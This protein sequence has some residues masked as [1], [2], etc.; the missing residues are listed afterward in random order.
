MAE[1]STHYL[2]S[3]MD[4]KILIYAQEG[5]IIT[6]TRSIAGQVLKHRLALI[7]MAST[8]LQY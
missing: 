7:F 1:H 3:S 4:G 6:Y 2:L 5:S 8:R